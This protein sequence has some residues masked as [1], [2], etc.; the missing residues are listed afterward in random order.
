MITLFPQFWT[1]LG[2]QVEPNLAPKLGQVG[3]KIGVLLQT[4]FQSNFERILE[5][6][7]IVF[8]SLLGSGMG[9]QSEL[10]I[11]SV[12]SHFFDSRLDGSSIFEVPR[13]SKID[14]KS[15]QT[16]LKIGPQ[17]KSQKSSKKLPT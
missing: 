9:P 7:G 3:L 6:L 1:P 16:A 17:C 14:Q 13:G 4:N 8:G 12:E 2:A 10:E 5:Y 15:M 11:R